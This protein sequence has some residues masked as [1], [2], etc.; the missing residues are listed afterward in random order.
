MK[1]QSKLAPS[2]TKEFLKESSQIILTAQELSKVRHREIHRKLNVVKEYHRSG[3]RVKVQRN[4]EVPIVQIATS[5]L[6]NKN[7][8][9]DRLKWAIYS[10]NKQKQRRDK[11]EKSKLETLRQEDPDIMTKSKSTNDLVAEA[12]QLQQQSDINNKRQ[13]IQLQ[14][15]SR[16]IQLSARNRDEKTLPSARASV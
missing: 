4:F 6:S 1:N 9:A 13:K 14:S 5:T 8:K 3:V 11:I 15:S 12:Q 2:N 10:K 16:R 7:S